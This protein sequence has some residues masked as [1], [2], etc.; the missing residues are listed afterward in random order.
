MTPNPVPGLDSYPC[1][2]PNWD[3]TPRSGSNGRVL[4]GS[5]PELFRAH[6]R[7]AIN[8]ASRFPAERRFVFIKSWN[9]WAEG[10]YLEPDRRFGHAYLEVLRDEIHRPVS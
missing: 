5:T 6:L 4:L 8:V 3:N 1:V 2:V 10:N 9:E 7:K